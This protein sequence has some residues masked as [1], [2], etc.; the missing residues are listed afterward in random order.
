MLLNFTRTLFQGQS[1][2][3]RISFILLMS[4]FEQRSSL[5]VKCRLGC[6]GQQFHGR[7]LVALWGVKPRK[8]FGLFKAEGQINNFKRRKFARILE[9]KFNTNLL[10]NKT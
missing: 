1:L 8:K 4:V 6:R 9:C 3:I 2:Y 10:Y 7:A 5:V